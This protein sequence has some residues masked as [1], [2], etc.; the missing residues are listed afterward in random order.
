[1]GSK[2]GSTSFSGNIRLIHSYPY[3]A[4]DVECKRLPPQ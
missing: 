4:S 1:M 3:V 2:A